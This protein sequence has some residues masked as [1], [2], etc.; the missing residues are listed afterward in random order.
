[1]DPNKWI[2]IKIPQD[3]I[4]HQAR[5][6]CLQ[7]PHAT[8]ARALQGGAVVRL[9][10]ILQLR[11]APRSRNRCRSLLPEKVGNLPCKD[12]CSVVNLLLVDV[13]FCFLGPCTV[14]GSKTKYTKHL[15]QADE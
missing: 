15:P 12:M 3:L 13:L 8:G 14:T 2:F 10:P 7:E 1:M 6:L 4:L 5:L 11:L 9:A